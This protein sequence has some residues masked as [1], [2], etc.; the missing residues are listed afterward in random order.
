MAEN[1]ANGVGTPPPLVCSAG[2]VRLHGQASSRKGPGSCGWSQPV[3]PV[4]LHIRLLENEEEARKLAQELQSATHLG[5]QALWKLF[6]DR[7]DFKSSR[8]ICL[9]VAQ[10]CPQCQMGSDYGHRQKTTGPFSPEGHGTLSQLTLWDLSP[11]TT[12][13]SASSCLWT[14][15]RGIPSLSPL[16]TT[17][18]TR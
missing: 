14:A 11:P 8:S 4:L 15:I 12:D 3:D 2:G 7:Y 9:E 17:P 6:R 1:D 5:G 18:Q 16:A 13:M 10:S